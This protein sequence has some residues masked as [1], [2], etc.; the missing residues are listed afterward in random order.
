MPYRYR[1][2]INHHHSHTDY[3]R[4][5]AIRSFRSCYFGGV[6]TEVAA[7]GLLEVWGSI[8]GEDWRY[9]SVIRVA[10]RAMVLHGVLHSV[11]FSCIPRG[12][13]I[14]L[15]IHTRPCI[16][17]HHF[18]IHNLYFILIFIGATSLCF[19]KVCI[20]AW[21]WLMLKAHTRPDANNYNQTLEH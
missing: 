17:F 9:S 6:C 15:C 10:D 21:M 16:V 3:Y 7:G 1:L 19:R 12:H 13:I 11:W 18:Y 5:H 2:H 8:W 4:S 20:D 14:L